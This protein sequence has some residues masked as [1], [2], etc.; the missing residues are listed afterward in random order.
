MAKKLGVDKS[1]LLDR[2]SS[3]MAVNLAKSETIIINQTKAWMRDQGIDLDLLDRIN[4]KE[5]KR[6][7]TTLLVKNIPYSTKQKDLQSIFER[8]G[9][10]KRLEISPFNTL[11]IIEYV[12]AMQAQAAARNLAYYKINFIMPIYLEFAPESV[13]AQQALKQAE[14]EAEPV[15]NT[16]AADQDKR[17]KTVFVKNLNF[18]TTDQ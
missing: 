6:S 10:I 11:A 9:E 12:S 17:L 13:V 15:E 7:R 8:Y 4:R 1:S 3:N 5:C 18:T 16:D 14:E 2:D